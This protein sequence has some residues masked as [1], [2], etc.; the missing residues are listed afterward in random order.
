MASGGYPDQFE[1]NKEISGLDSV[2]KT[3]T[4]IFHAGTEYKNGKVYSRGG[5]VLGVA[6]VADQLS[7]AVEQA[8]SVIEKIHFEKAHYRKDI[9]YRA[10]KKNS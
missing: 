2:D 3:N 5:R 1:Q 4:F 9:A 7:K 10:L 8:Y 6:S